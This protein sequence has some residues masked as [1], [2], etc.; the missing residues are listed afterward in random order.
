MQSF[1]IN[2]L[3]NCMG[4]EVNN[5]HYCSFMCFLWS[6]SKETSNK[7]EKNKNHAKSRDVIRIKA[8]TPRYAI[9]S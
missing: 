1:R 5:K 2:T 3:T 8:I 4:W 7:S 6:S 9:N